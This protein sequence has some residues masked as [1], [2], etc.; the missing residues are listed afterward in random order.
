M[1]TRTKASEKERLSKVIAGI[2]IKDIATS[3]SRKS[4]IQN[5]PNALEIKRV[6]AYESSLARKKEK[7]LSNPSFEKPSFEN[8]PI[9][10]TTSSKKPSSK[11]IHRKI[12]QKT[13]Y[14]FNEEKNKIKKI[15]C[16][17]SIREINPNPTHKQR[18]TTNH[19]NEGLQTFNLGDVNT[20]DNEDSTLLSPNENDKTK[21]H[22]NDVEYYDAENTMESDVSNDGFSNDGFSN[23]ET[24]YHEAEEILENTKHDSEA[25]IEKEEIDASLLY[26][27]SLP[28]SCVVM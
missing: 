4:S 11:R 27:I 24:E 8:P 22:A 2:N 16:T 7:N 17:K 18:I 28:R 5:K 6:L 13:T 3:Y 14:M 9:R 19:A 23:D 26:N 1:S 20:P 21:T 12:T 15:V 10:K 25:E